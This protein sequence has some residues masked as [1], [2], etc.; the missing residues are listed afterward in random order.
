MFF[1]VLSFQIQNFPPY[2]MLVSVACRIR[3]GFPHL[4]YRFSIK[5]L[6]YFKT[7]HK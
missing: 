3:N 7:T 2:R 6:F 1:F 5:F 4:S